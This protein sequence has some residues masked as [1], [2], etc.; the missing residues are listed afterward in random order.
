MASGVYVSNKVKACEYVGIKVDV[1]RMPE[2][3]KQ[4]DLNK[5]IRELNRDDEVDAILL[6]LPLPHHLNSSEAINYISPEKDVD[7]LTDVS[8]GKLLVGDHTGFVS[9]TPSAVIEFFKEYKIDLTGKRVALI[10]RSILVGK[11]LALLLLKNNATVTICHSKTKNLKQVTKSADIV[12]SAAGKEKL[13]TADMVKKNAVVID[14]GINRNAE[15]RLCGDVDYNNVSQV[16]KAIT[17]VPGGVGPMTV[18]M[19]LSNV[20]KAYKDKNNIK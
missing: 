6:Q 20:M 2:D 13:V 1:V 3:T 7:G 10:G 11:P 17:P 18:A 15:G 5:T 12:I 9:C 19:M 14:V 4:A 8:L 16:A